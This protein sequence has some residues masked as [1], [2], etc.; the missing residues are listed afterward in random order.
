MRDAH[1]AGEALRHADVV[2]LYLSD[3]GNASILPLLRES[4]KPSA[5]SRSNSTH[6]TLH[7]PSALT[8][9]LLR[10]AACGELRV[11]DAGW[12][13]ALSIVASHQVT[14]PASFV[15]GPRTAGARR[16]RK[17]TLSNR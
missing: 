7:W 15:R 9:A 2:T 4:L 6:Q 3:R 12:H 16:E 8:A 10:Q 11:D 17:L 5:V 13:Q 14:A 1:D